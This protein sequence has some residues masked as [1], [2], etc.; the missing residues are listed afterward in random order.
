MRKLFILLLCLFALSMGALAADAEITGLKADALVEEDG[1]VQIN[2]TAEVEF[3]GA[4]QSFRLPLGTDAKKITLAGWDY[5]KTEVD[6][7]TCLVLSNPAGFSGRQTFVCSY[8]LP[9]RVAENDA[10]QR[11][12]LSLPEAGWEYAI[13]SYALTVNFPTE[14]TS[15]PSWSSGYYEDV[16]DNYLDITVSGSTVSVQ[17]IAEMKDH[18]TILMRLQFADDSFNLQ[19]LPGRARTITALFF[20]LFFVLAPVYWFFRLRYRLILPKAQPMATE[21][22][23]GEIPCELFGDV[24]DAAGILAHWGNL[25][26]VI[27]YRTS[28]GGIYVQKQME[29]GNERKAAER[30]F[31][32]ALFRSGDTCDVRSSR[33]LT[34]VK[35]ME[36][37]MR[38]SW[39]RRM[40]HPR[41]GNPRLM[42]LL[43][44][45]GGLCIS[46]MTFDALLPASGARWVFLPLLTAV[47]TSLYVLIQR[48]V[49]AFYRRRRVLR[50]CLAGGAVFTL[51][52]FAAIS[53]TVL[54][55]LLAILLQGFCALTVIFGGK[56]TEVGQDRV[57]RLLGLRRYLCRTQTAELQKLSYYDPQYYYRMLPYAEA[58]G[59]GRR[60]SARVGTTL[61]EPC[62]WLYDARPLPTRP[63]DFYQVYEEIFSALRGE[64]Y[65]AQGAASPAPAPKAAPKRPAAAASSRRPHRSREYDFDE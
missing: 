57:R 53:G 58:L 51:F 35:T 54:F 64:Y 63:A 7:V 42:Q 32:H 39:L 25:G 8:R 13:K 65:R 11:F 14:V 56:R 4:P 21:T 24:P 6:G 44:L 62:P 31:F 50:L 10:G 9:C 60:F 5:D 34:A 12:T 40:F 36:K 52:L 3:T 19:N 23:A 16:I 61:I 15:Q 29:M 37:P 38:R 47:G 33:F 26:Y 2:L 28:R 49:A 1:S 59:V 27:L 43:G 48:G 45:L 55:S 17:S 30:K 22:A 20:L 46:L 41:S 18:E